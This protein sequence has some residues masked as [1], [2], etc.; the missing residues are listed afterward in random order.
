MLQFVD[1]CLVRFLRQEARLAESDVAISFD[2][3]DATWGASVTRPTVNLFLWDIRRHGTESSGGLALGPDGPVLGL[4]RAAVQ[5]IVTVWTSE[6]TDQHHLLGSIMTS[7]VSHP[8]VP[9]DC[10]VEEMATLEPPP[11]LRVSA[12]DELGRGNFWTSLGGNLRAALDLV[13]GFTVDPSVFPPSPP[14]RRPI[15]RSGFLGGSTDGSTNGTT[16]DE[17]TAERA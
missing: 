12:T 13:V 1:A 11:S 2:T 15:F 16:P 6:V 17:A 8:E 4:T 14:V 10:I 9:A 3:P 5:Y 7:V